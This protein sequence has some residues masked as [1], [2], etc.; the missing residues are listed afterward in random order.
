M[1]I[2]MDKLAGPVSPGDIIMRNEEA[3]RGAAALLNKMI[4]KGTRGMYKLPEAEKEMPGFMK[5]AMEN[6]EEVKLDASDFRTILKLLEQGFSMEDIET[7]TQASMLRDNAKTLNEAAP[8]GEMLAYI[9][10]EEAGVLKLL[11]G[12][13]QMTPS[14]IPSFALRPINHQI[15]TKKVLVL[16]KTALVDQREAYIAGSNMPSGQLN[17]L[18]HLLTRKKKLFKQV[19]MKKIM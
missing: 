17:L 12:A 1:A 15:K 13:G 11:G 7:M 6:M 10:P 8:E 2:G 3:P 16:F 14:G 4:N 19:K 5:D 9:N 18:T